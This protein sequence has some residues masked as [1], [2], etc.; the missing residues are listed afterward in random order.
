MIRDASAAHPRENFQLGRRPGL[1]SREGFPSYGEVGL[2]CNMD[3]VLHS[4]RLIGSDL[5]IKIAKHLLFCSLDHSVC[6][7]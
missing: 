1:S 2:E 6:A 5:N 3:E 4:A 7:I